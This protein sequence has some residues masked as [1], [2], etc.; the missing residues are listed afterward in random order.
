MSKS[1]LVLDYDFGDITGGENFN[2]EVKF[3]PKKEFL[4]RKPKIF[5]SVNDNNWN[6]EIR[7]NEHK[8]LTLTQM[9]ILDNE[10]LIKETNLLEL[11][12]EKQFKNK[13]K[14]WSE[15]LDEMMKNNEDINRFMNDKNRQIR[16]MIRNGEQTSEA[17]NFI[18]KAR[19]YVPH[20][21]VFV[22]KI[23]EEKTVN[24][25]PIFEEKVEEDFDDED[26][27]FFDEQ[28]NQSSGIDYAEWK[29]FNDSPSEID[30]RASKIA[31]IMKAGEDK[32]PIRYYAKDGKLN[33]AVGFSNI[34]GEADFDVKNVVQKN[35][36][37]ALTVKFYQT[38][39][40][41]S[42]QL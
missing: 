31:K 27:G 13:I 30:E 7:Q 34:R 40:E 6:Y 1:G 41:L 19:G 42:N 16:H 36:N 15:E 38:K 5:N 24:N 26:D 2:Y 25:K 23:D 37:P 4:T 12:N 28:Q 17:L 29:N 22:N 9:M 39:K 14:I 32:I 21:K 20:A 35:G 8:P 3:V 18:D 10:K 33:G 11:Y